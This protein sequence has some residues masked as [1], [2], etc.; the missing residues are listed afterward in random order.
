MSQPFSTTRPKHSAS[1]GR[2][3]G[4]SVA[5]FD[6][7]FGRLRR[8]SDKAHAGKRKSGRLWETAGFED[9]FLIM[10]IYCCCYVTQELFG[11]FYR[12]DKSPI[13]RAIKRI[14]ALAKPLFGVQREPRP[15]REK[16]EAVMLY[17][18]EQPV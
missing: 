16:T 2:L 14:E 5:T 1:F 6:T 18:T 17:C 4:V 9:H 8:P 11:F 10:L 7:I 12:V 15:S 13:C 3:T